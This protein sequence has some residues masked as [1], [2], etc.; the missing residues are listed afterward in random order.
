M[1]IQY[2]LKAFWYIRVLELR[3]LRFDHVM[4]VVRKEMKAGAIVAG[5]NC[6]RLHLNTVKLLSFYIHGL[7]FGNASFFSRL[8]SKELVFLL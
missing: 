1:T 7:A 5:Q 6:L 2:T 8:Y 4:S 3:K